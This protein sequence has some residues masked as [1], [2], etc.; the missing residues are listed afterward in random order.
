ML[1]AK[2]RDLSAGLLASIAPATSVTQILGIG[3]SAG[4]TCLSVQ[5]IKESTVTIPDAWKVL[6][7]DN[8]PQPNRNSE[9]C[10]FLITLNGTF[11]QMQSALSSLAD[12]SLG[13][14]I[15][16]LNMIPIDGQADQRSWQWTVW[17][18]SQLP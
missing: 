12:Q 5:P 4:L 10:E 7:N 1:V 11:A 13:C 14:R 3:Q 18:G 8:S 16:S 17:L 2:R 6:A 15:L 9:H